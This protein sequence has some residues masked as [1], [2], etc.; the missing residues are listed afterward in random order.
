MS[1]TKKS[2]AESIAEVMIAILPV[3]N[4]AVHLMMIRRIAVELAIATAFFSGDINIFI[5]MKRTIYSKACVN[6]IK[7]NSK[8]KLD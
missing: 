1:E 6:S 2:K 3:S 4:H 8:G 7:K 5:L